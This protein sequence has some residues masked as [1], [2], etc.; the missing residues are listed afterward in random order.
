MF[1]FRQ[2]NWNC[3]TCKKD[4]GLLAHAY[5]TDEAATSII[6]T[7]QGDLFCKSHF[8]N[9]DEIQMVFCQDHI[10]IFMPPALKLISSMLSSGSQTVCHYYF[11]GICEAP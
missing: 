8:L 1:R 7:L 10:E 9:L 4:I 3:D 2:S 11:E 6:K 5:G